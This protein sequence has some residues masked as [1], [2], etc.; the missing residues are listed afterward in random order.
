MDA[1]RRLSTSI[2]IKR[3]YRISRPIVRVVSP[4][5][6]DGTALKPHPFGAVLTLWAPPP[7]RPPPPYHHHHPPRPPHLHRSSAE[8]CA[9]AGSSRRN[10][11]HLESRSPFA[12]FTL[13]SFNPSCNRVSWTSSSFINTAPIGL[14]WQPLLD[15]RLPLLGLGRTLSSFSLCFYEKR[16]MKT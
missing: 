14:P 13:M 10:L 16:N 2:I 7:T 6:R 9:A 11:K 12:A 8:S 4:E 5:A 15:C 1:D 3:H